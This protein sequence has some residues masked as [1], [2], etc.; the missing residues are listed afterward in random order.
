MVARELLCIRRQAS[1]RGTSGALLTTQ[2]VLPLVLLGR[3]LQSMRFKQ[4]A[5]MRYSEQMQ[6]KYTQRGKLPRD[7]AN[8]KGTLQEG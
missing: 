5:S 6:E 4:V 2:C 1:K 8:G 3:S 7:K